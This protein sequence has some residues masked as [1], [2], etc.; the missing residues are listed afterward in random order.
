MVLEHDFCKGQH[1]ACY[2]IIQN[3][4]VCALQTHGPKLPTPVW[5]KTSLHPVYPREVKRLDTPPTHTHTQGYC[6][7]L[8]SL[9]NNLSVAILSIEASR[10][11]SVL[12]AKPIA[13]GTGGHVVYQGTI[14]LL[15][16][17]IEIVSHHVT[18]AD[19]ELTRDLPASAFLC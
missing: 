19:L 7:I 3:K 15:L 10:C 13:R 2:S 16:L 17:F 6:L 11:F 18:L 14:L 8:T 12:T 9:H 5:P 1:R 4:D